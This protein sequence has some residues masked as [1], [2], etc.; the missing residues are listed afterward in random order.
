LL[1]IGSVLVHE[2][3][4]IGSGGFDW[5]ESSLPDSFGGDC[6]CGLDGSAVVLSA[7]S[8]LSALS[9]LS[10][11]STF[12]VLSTFSAPIALSALVATSASSALFAFAPL[13]RLAWLRVVGR[14]AFA[15]L[16]FFLAAD[17]A[18]E[19]M[20]SSGDWSGCFGSRVSASSSSSDFFGGGVEDLGFWVFD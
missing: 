4:T 13:L 7:L 20:G 8:S 6:E 16:V 19:A 2:S 3:V 15:G 17:E 12:S 1:R 9:A 18:S 10:A 5:Y 11:L 14:V